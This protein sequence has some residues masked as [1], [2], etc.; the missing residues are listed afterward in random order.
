MIFH[1]IPN[2]IADYHKPAIIDDLHNIVTYDDLLVYEHIYRSHF[3]GKNLVFILADNTSE[4]ACFYIS[5]INL[6]QAIFLLNP[7]WNI[8]YIKLYITDYSPQY[9][10]L[11]E[12]MET[13]MADF[14]CVVIH[15]TNQHILC[16]TNHARFSVND[17]LCVLLTTSGSTGNPKTVRLSKKN[18]INNMDMFA[19][20]LKICKDDKGFLSL[21]FYHAY[22]LAVLNAHIRSGATIVL[23]EMKTHE[24]LFE[25]TIINESI[26]NLHGVPY[27]YK[28]VLATGFLNRLPQS[29]R[30][31]TVSGGKMSEELFDK[32]HD[33]L[34]R[35]CIDFFVLYGQT[36]GTALLSGYKV[37][38]YNKSSKGIGYPCYQLR[39]SIDPHNSELCFEGD[40]VSMGYAY[41]C[42]D[43]K[44][45]DTNNGFLRTGDIVSVDSSGMYH[46]EGR[47]NRIIKLK[48]YRYNLDDVEQNLEKY[49]GCEIVCCGEDDLLK[50]FYTGQLKED[51]IINRIT[52]QFMISARNVQATKIL[53]VPRSAT[54]K[55]DYY[56][57]TYL[58]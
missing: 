46:I 56:T 19:K 28:K 29:V 11:P 24:H 9:I 7:K 44:L 14:N 42:S 48:G 13:F 45:G 57:L 15:R 5:A 6:N 54:G 8:E 20:F 25:Q 30:F 33:I 37:D 18:I 27:L 39:A 31:L 32:M 38:R 26:T 22:G 34:A 1:S 17:E 43:L 36:E 23:S 10:W 16:R 53:N 41:S 58:K 52:K 21:P 51:N 4:S 2:E 50:I 40:S 35:Q 55:I 47:L 49:F 3:T 12:V